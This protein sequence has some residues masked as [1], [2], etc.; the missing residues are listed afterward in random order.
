MAFQTDLLGLFSL[1]DIA[2]PQDFE[3]M[4]ILRY[5]YYL[6]FETDKFIAA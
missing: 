1:T 2:I 5:I 3:E 4:H 6:I